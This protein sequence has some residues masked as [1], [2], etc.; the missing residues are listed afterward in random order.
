MVA[1]ESMVELTSP[2]G[3]FVTGPGVDSVASR[4]LGGCAP[5]TKPQL[6]A[7]NDVVSGQQ[8]GG[9]VADGQDPDVGVS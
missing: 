7:L 1:K 5:W 2:A 4:Q 3:P 8:G 9:F 6:V